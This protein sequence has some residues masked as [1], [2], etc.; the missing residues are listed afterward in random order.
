M[1]DLHDSIHQYFE[2][3]NRRDFDTAMAAFALDASVRDEGH[4]YKG[5][6]EIKAWMKDA[7]G[8]Y[9]PTAEVLSS[10]AENENTIVEARVTGS[11][12]GSP[13]AVR[14]FFMLSD[15]KISTLETRV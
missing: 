2:A 10:R 6:S 12:P 13:V 7:A 1:T 15:G 8:K 11:F 9:A 3:T 14:F 5:H 4:A